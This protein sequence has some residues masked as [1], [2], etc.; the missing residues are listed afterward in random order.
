MKKTHIVTKVVV[1]FLLGEVVS[2]KKHIVKKD[3]VRSLLGEVVSMEKNTS[4]QR[5][6]LA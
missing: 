5:M 2:T 6:W 4:L 1:G 3:V